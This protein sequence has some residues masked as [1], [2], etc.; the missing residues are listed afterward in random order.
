MAARQHSIAGRLRSL[1]Q[2][3]IFGKGARERQV[4]I[5]NNHVSG[6]LASYL[7]SKQNDVLRDV[8][9]FESAAGNRITLDDT[10]G[11]ESISLQDKNGATP[12]H[13][14]VRTRCA[15][16]VKLLLESGANYKL[17]NKPGSTP[18]HLA[19]QNTGRGGS[20]APEAIE[21]H[22]EIIQLFRSAGISSAIEDAK[23][24]SVL[25]SARSQWIR[26]ILTDRDIFLHL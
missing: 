24:K 18:F 2:G 21:A 3:G 20:G 17:Q 22:R 10:S 5:T 13:R 14:A 7:R 8:P 9:L 11:S 1:G 4:F 25:D 26:D 23:G 15:A 16:A 19:V 6:E 12:L